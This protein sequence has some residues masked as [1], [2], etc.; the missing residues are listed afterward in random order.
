MK[1]TIVIVLVIAMVM[2]LGIVTAVAALAP[3]Y[4]G[5][6]TG[7][8]TDDGAGN[9]SG[10]V[11]GDYA[12]TITGVFTS[13]SGQYAT[14]NADVTGDIVGTITGGLSLVNG[15]D[16]LYAVITGTGASDPVRIEGYF[17]KTGIKGDFVGEIITGALPAP[18]TSLGITTAGDATVV[19]AGSTLQ[20]TADM[21]PAGYEVLWSVWTSDDVTRASIDQN[22]LLSALEAGAVTVIAN[23]LDPSL[24]TT[25]KTITIVDPVTA[26]AGSID[27]S[28][29]IVIPAAVDF[30]AMVKGSGKIGMEFTVEAQSVVLE[31]GYRIKVGV[32]SAFVMKDNDG[33]GTIPLVYS[34]AN[35]V[36]TVMVSGSVFA[37]FTG[38]G[39]EIGEISV[40]T[41]SITKAGK[42]KGAMVFSIAYEAV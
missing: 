6:V 34:L 36:P 7:I 4:N 12:L 40:D 33:I 39:T 20:C 3:P 11:T 30:G 26:V 29:V 10:S 25:T 19:D 14:F 37:L 5:S 21:T 42:Y 38:N 27:P 15:I 41:D 16:T 31:D 23:T 28:Y 32:V 17:P 13:A 9:I 2:G 35:S 18:V 8:I 24:A 22:G 1:K